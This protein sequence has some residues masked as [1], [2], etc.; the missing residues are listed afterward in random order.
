MDTATAEHKPKRIES[1]LVRVTFKAALVCAGLIA[2]C[3]VY[4]LAR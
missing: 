1:T 3:D 2:V 4:V